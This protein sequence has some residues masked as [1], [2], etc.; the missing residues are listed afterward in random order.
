MKYTLTPDLTTGNALIDSQHR[1]LLDTVNTLM[2]ACSSGKGREQIQSTLTFLN[3][4]DLPQRLCGQ[5]LPG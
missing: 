4:P 5:A 2:D 1:L 3:Y